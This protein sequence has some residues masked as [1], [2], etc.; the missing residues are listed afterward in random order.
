MITSGVFCF[1]TGTV[2][3][4]SLGQRNPATDRDRNLF[5]ESTESPSSA[6]KMGNA[7]I[8]EHPSGHSMGDA[9]E[10][11]RRR[12]SGDARTTRCSSERDTSFK[13][14]DSEDRHR[15]R[16]SNPHSSEV[17]ASDQPRRFTSRR[18]P[19]RT[20]ISPDRSRAPEHVSVKDDT[21]R[22]SSRRHCDE[23][24]TTTLRRERDG[25]APETRLAG[26]D[27][28]SKS[29]MRESLAE[30]SARHS[31]RRRSLS[32]PRASGAPR[33]R[34]PRDRRSPMR[35]SEIS[36]DADLRGGRDREGRRSRISRERSCE[37]SRERHLSKWRE[38]DLRRDVARGASPRTIRFGSE[39][40]GAPDSCPASA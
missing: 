26:G 7:Q 23:A 19:A 5:K 21:G 8:S 40:R 20:F 32:S 13:E 30:R 36:R 10:V 29:D 1:R 2:P 15:L 11:A 17:E 27:K 31:A 25:N 22:R 14:P 39:D 6:G 37:R 3:E 24:K 4:T 33:E 18:S 9:H 38:R 16:S 12:Y 34:P 35:Q 28:C